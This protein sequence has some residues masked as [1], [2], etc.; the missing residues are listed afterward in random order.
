M[1]VAAAGCSGEI[2]AEHNLGLVSN[3]M[4]PDRVDKLLGKPSL[5]NLSFEPSG[6]K[7]YF[8][9]GKLSDL[10]KPIHD[11]PHAFSNP[12]AS[13]FAM[14]GVRPYASQAEVDAAIVPSASGCS[15]YKVNDNFGFEV[16]FKSRTVISKEKISSEDLVADL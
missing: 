3:G 6:Y 7:A 14:L 9:M 2:P 15:F 11:N 8:K 10:L 13:E 1:V 16:C 4:S 12:T 5:A